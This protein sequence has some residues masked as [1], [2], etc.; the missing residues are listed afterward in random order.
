MRVN[1]PAL[2]VTAELTGE[3]AKAIKKRVWVPSEGTQTRFR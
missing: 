3:L 1:V 2:E